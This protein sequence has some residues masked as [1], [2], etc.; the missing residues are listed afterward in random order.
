MIFETVMEYV[1][2]DIH[3]LLS[4]YHILPSSYCVEMLTDFFFTLLSIL[5][6]PVVFL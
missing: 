4:M 6:K 2:V 3:C 5:G 1:C